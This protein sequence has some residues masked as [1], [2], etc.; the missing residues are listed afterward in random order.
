MSV[1]Y[2]SKA[3][4]GFPLRSA[5]MFGA[6]QHIMMGTNYGYGT[7]PPGTDSVLIKFVKGFDICGVF[8]FFSMKIKIESAQN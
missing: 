4:T 7:L 5:L 2:A 8:E 3:S 6:S 1:H